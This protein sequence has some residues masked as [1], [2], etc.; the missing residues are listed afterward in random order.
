MLKKTTFSENPKFGLHEKFLIM[1]ICKLKVDIFSSLKT[2]ASTS[3][4]R[5]Q[6][7]L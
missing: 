7:A 5:L 6:M 2:E 1:V 4:M 3:D